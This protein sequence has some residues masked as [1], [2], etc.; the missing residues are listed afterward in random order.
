MTRAVSNAA[1]RKIKAF[2]TWV[3]GDQRAE[4]VMTLPQLRQWAGL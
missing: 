1:K 3:L 4:G 2:P